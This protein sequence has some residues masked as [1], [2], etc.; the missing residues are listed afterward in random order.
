MPDNARRPAEQPRP[1]AHRCWPPRGSGCRWRS[2]SR[3]WSL[4]VVGHGARTA[5]AGAGVVGLVIVALIVWMINWMFRLSVDS[6]REREPRGGG[7]RVLRPARALAG[8]GAAVTAGADRAPTD[9]DGRRQRHAGLVLRRRALPR[10][11]RRRSRTGWSSRPRA[12]RSSTSAASRP[13]RARSR[14]PRTRSSRRVVPVI[15]GLSPAGAQAQIS[16]DTSKAA[17]AAR[18]AGGRRHAR[19]RRH[20]AARATREMAERRGRRRGATAA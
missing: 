2:R 20:R 5:T 14:S 17:V 15:E 3:A 16:I 19:Q 9:R 8:R 7:A 10:R 4:I 13:A 12:P 1:D 11:R 6:N 18:G